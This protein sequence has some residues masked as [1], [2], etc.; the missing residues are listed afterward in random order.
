MFSFNGMR[1]GESSSAE[2]SLLNHMWAKVKHSNSLIQYTADSCL[3]DGKHRKKCL[4]NKSIRRVII[5]VVGTAFLCTGKRFLL[6][7]M[8]FKAEYC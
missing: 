8:N 4:G 7:Q 3:T 2:K 1:D 5:V 6:A